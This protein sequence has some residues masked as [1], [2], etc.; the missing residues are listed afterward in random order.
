MKKNAFIFD[1]NK[2][3]GCM[4]CVVACTIENGTH[5]PLNWRVVNA[6]NYI[7]HPNLPVF[8]FSLACNHCDDAPCMANCPALAYSRDEKTGAII[9]NAEAC[10]GCTYC[11]WACPYDAPKL[12][13]N[14]HIV[15]KCNFC[16]DRISE[17]LKPACAMACPVGALDFAPNE[18]IDLKKHLM[19]GFVNADIGPSIQ[20]IPLR[21]EHE[22]PIIENIDAPLID[23]E[24]VDHYLPNLQSKV[25]LAKE[26]TLVLFSFAAASLVAWLGAA[27]TSNV[28]I[29]P[30]IFVLLGIVSIVLSTMHVGKKL[31][32]WRFLSNLKGS[33]LSREIFSF[34]AFFGLGTLSLFMKENLLGLGDLLFFVESKT[35]GFVAVGFGAFTLVSVDRVYKFFIRKDTLKLH[36]AMAWTTGILLFAWIA[37]TPLLIGL[38]TLLKAYLYIYRKYILHTH[39][40]A[41]LP[42]ASSIRLLALLLPFV[43]LLI[44]P[45]ISLW[46]LLPIVFM[47]EIID[48]IEFYHESDVRT[49][50]G[51][52]KEL[53]CKTNK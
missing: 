27:V 7:K 1:T 14:T 22:K 11:T 28:A 19:P 20:L 40:I 4:A 13:E 37:H 30:L 42:I 45:T 31:R 50:Q 25:D 35:V 53:F 38:M 18:E 41:Y 2:C 36:S 32:I 47:G 15:E 33:W 17:G 5:T 9:H 49:P 6:H 29:S 10:I 23:A 16:V 46:I 39:K 8:H 34:S 43:A 44:V 21:K 12:N 3:V 24:K 48:R 26:W 52:M 51:E